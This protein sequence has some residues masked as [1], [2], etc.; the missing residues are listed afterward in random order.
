V[1]RLRLVALALASCA[2]VASGCGS[3]A[4]SA[5]RATSSTASSSNASSKVSSVS[6][7]SSKPSGPLTHAQLIAKGDAICYRVNA[8]R[9]SLSYG[10]PKEYE[11]VVPPLA[12]YELRAA[13]EMGEL[14]APHTLSDAWRKIV[15]GSRT[16]AEVTGRFPHFSEASNAT[17]SH[18]YRVLLSKTI[19]D[20]TSTAK[21]AG[22]K[23]CSRFL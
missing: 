7:K 1:S 2:L 13:N 19:A 18:R 6:G 17:L 11:Q 5:R 4:K 9:Q 22:F 23:E 14:A 16:I 21:H 8:R 10:T 20:V 3:S 12:A 15:L